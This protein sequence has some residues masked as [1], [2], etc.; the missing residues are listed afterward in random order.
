MG[1]RERAG[2]AGP[3][4]D[5]GQG[6]GWKRQR[7][8]DDS[9]AV[10]AANA[11]GVQT[12][13]R[14]SGQKAAPAP[15]ASKRATT[16]KRKQQAATANGKQQAAP[17]KGKQAAAA[18]TKDKKAA[19]AGKQPAAAADTVT[20]N[21]APVLTLWVA[22]VSERQG[23]SWDAG[24]TFGRLV[25]GWLAQSK[26]RSLGMYEERVEEDEEVR[27]AKARRDANMG[28]PGGGRAAGS[29]WLL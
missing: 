22:V 12:R 1:K 25:S 7:P 5:T 11:S 15:A 18:P 28:K 24:L 16:S 27:E 6:A 20:I 29:A 9:A 17:G 21:R 23:H 2:E 10:G 3:A 14:S 13:T 26:G 8:A 19:H 4:S